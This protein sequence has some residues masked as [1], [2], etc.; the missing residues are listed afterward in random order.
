M[1]FSWARKTH[2]YFWD[3]PS[4]R[5]SLKDLLWIQNLLWTTVDIHI[6]WN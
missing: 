4:F 2:S 1:L 6:L 3:E 5:K